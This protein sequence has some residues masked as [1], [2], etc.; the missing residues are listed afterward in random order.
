MVAGL[1][2]RSVPL[3]KKG[4]ELLYNEGGFSQREYEHTISELDGFKDM[5]F[6]EWVEEEKQRY[7]A[8]K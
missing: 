3:V 4:V 7:Q 2:G 1:D 5:S 8:K 6:E